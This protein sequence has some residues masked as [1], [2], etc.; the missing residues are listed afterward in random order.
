MF[1]STKSQIKNY[2]DEEGLE[3]SNY[4]IDCRKNYLPV[5]TKRVV[6]YASNLNEQFALKTI[7]VKLRWAYRFL[8]RHGF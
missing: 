2:T 1:L 7:N 6:S 5:S 4:I 3:I 8:K